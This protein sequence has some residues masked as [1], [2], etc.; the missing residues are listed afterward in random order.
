MSHFSSGVFLTR[1]ISV[2]PLEPESFRP[3]NPAKKNGK[4]NRELSINTWREKVSL[5]NVFLLSKSKKNEIAVVE[6]KRGPSF[7]CNFHRPLDDQNGLN[8]LADSH[9]AGTIYRTSDSTA[10]TFRLYCVG[11]TAFLSRSGVLNLADTILIPGRTFLSLSRY[12][13]VGQR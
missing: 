2:G 4:R 1:S 13:P 12:M 3:T 11:N 5:G 7:D 9:F 6:I 10:S 8:R